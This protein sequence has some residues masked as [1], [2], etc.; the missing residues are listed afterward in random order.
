MVISLQ[1]GCSTARQQVTKRCDSHKKH[2]K[3][4]LLKLLRRSQ[5][6]AHTH[7]HKHTDAAA[8]PEVQ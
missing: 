5:P 2:K 8:S 1:Y 3:L 6:A 7:C 4:L